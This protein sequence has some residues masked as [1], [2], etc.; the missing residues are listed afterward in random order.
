MLEFRKT[1]YELGMCS[2]IRRVFEQLETKEFNISSNIS[3]AY[4]MK[5]REKKQLFIKH[6]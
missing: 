5:V 6:L 2:C 1:F 4:R 3:I